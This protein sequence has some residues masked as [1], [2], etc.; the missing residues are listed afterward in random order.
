MLSRL[1]PPVYLG[2]R[3]HLGLSGSIAAYRLL[4]VARAWTKAGLGVGAT[5]TASA[6]RFVTPLSLRALGADPVLTEMFPEQG[7]V[8][9]HLRP[10]HEAQAM[11]IAPASATTLSRLA[12]GL[13]DEILACQALAFPHPLI[14]APAMNPAMWANPATQAN[15]D[16]L[17]QRGHVL[18][19]PDDGG[20]ACGDQG[21]GRLCAVEEIYF[22]GL[23]ALTPPTL[24]GK[25][26][27]VTLGPTH[28]YFDAAR[29]WS[30]PSTG[31]MGACIVVAAWLQGAE[32]TA[33]CGPGCPSLPRSIQRLDVVS[34][35]QMHEAALDR[36]ADMDVAIC[37]AAVADFSPV[38]H[39]GGKFKKEG[40]DV[41]RPEFTR[42]P[43][44]LH[45][46]GQAKRSGQRLVGFAAE[47]G[48]LAMHAAD[49][50]R[51]KHADLL[52]ANRIGVQDSGFASATNAVY[53]LDRQGR[54]EW[55]PVLPKAEVAWRLLEWLRN[56]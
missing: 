43:D 14:I 17:R 36:W 54:A 47:T 41:F 53:A 45:S 25:R 27:L 15:R 35:R 22:H 3:L 40:A 42:S 56:L 34:A 20:A 8:F 10:L 39:D 44:I 9:P 4:D 52:L 30:N 50:L 37:A 2:R 19:D 55:W 6:Q 7:D 18:L 48:E 32:V 23:R 13:A 21:Q 16:L 38:P 5:L 33:L 28:E 1:T 31:L 46:L 24:A 49:K 11:V 26:L 12:H 51:R 29:Y